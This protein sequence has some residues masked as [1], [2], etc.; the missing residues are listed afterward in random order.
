MLFKFQCYYFAPTERATGSV[1]PSQ[2]YIGLISSQTRDTFPGYVIHK[3]PGNGDCMFS[4]I[5]HQLSVS[6]GQPPV[7]SNVIRQQLVSYV[8]EHPKL[9]SHLADA[10]L[11]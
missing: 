6:L 1:R 4:A 11:T 10:G 9:T 2:P 8:K 7:S 5:A 3:Q